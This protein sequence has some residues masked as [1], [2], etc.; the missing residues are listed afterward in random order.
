[1]YDEDSQARSTF[2]NKSE[3][4]RSSTLSVRRGYAWLKYH[5][6]AHAA[7]TEDRN[8]V[9]FSRIKI[10]ALLPVRLKFISYH[11]ALYKSDTF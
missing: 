4:N 6:R 1:M 3:H 7:E 10:H 5:E 9:G 2:E 11:I 8:K